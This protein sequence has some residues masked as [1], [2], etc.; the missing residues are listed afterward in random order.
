[1][2]RIEMRTSLISRLTQNA[3]VALGSVLSCVLY[4]L[5]FDWSV[6]VSVIIVLVAVNLF[7]LNVIRLALDDEVV[8]YRDPQL[9]MK[10][11]QVP[12]REIKDVTF[13]SSWGKGMVLHLYRGESFKQRLLFMGRFNFALRNM[14]RRSGLHVPLWEL[15]MKPEQ[16]RSL[17]LKE[18]EEHTGFT[19]FPS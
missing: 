9:S 18:F 2:N 3:I 4:G 15:D 13:R 5:D 1:M 11:L 10:P 12:W 8:Y 6:F 7:Y 17:I 14:F 19:T 16:I